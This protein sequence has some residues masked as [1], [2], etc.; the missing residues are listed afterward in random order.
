MI[1]ISKSE[2][3]KNHLKSTRHFKWLIINQIGLLTCQKIPSF[4][5]P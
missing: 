1:S 4:V 3:T 2:D 5:A